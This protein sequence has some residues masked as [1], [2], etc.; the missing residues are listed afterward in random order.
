MQSASRLGWRRVN[1]K[2]ADFHP[3]GFC[4]IENPCNFCL[5]IPKHVYRGPIDC[6]DCRVCG[7]ALDMPCHDDVILGK[8]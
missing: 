6:A 8:H 7:F 1:K 2:L 4:N 5:A 3:K